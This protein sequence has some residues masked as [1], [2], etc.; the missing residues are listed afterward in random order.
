[1]IRPRSDLPLTQT[2]FAHARSWAQTFNGKL[3]AP[4]AETGA[5]K[6]KFGIG[7]RIYF[8]QSLTRFGTDSIRTDKTKS[9]I[10]SIVVALIIF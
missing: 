4:F 9:A 5:G 1:M 8:Y 6:F 3:Q 7:L 10:R 2:L